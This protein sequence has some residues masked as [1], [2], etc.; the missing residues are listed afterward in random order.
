V[1][2]VIVVGRGFFLC[3]CVSICVC[4]CVYVCDVLSYSHFC[5]IFTLVFWLFVIFRLENFEIVV[6]RL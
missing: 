4:M 5:V 1:K 3:P 2:F 6:S